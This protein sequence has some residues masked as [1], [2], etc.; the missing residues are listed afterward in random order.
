MVPHLHRPLTLT[1]RSSA[2]SDLTHGFRIVL[3]P[4]VHASRYTYSFSYT[5]T[6]YSRSFST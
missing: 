6:T 3:A 4:T 1:L 5:L 2:S